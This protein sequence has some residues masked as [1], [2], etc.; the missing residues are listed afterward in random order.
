MPSVGDASLPLPTLPL[1]PPPWRSLLVL[2]PQAVEDQ[3]TQVREADD[4]VVW[5]ALGTSYHGLQVQPT[6]QRIVRVL[7]GAALLGYQ[8]G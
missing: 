7:G 5:Q 4:A 2:I 6:Q 1:H 8:L 3:W